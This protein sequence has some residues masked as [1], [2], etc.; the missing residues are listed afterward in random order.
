[1]LKKNDFLEIDFIARVKGTE[2][3]FDTTLLEEAKKANMLTEEDEKKEKEVE[4]SQKRFKP[5]KLCIGQGMVIAGLDKALEGKETG[6][7]Y[8]VE[9]QPQD[10]FGLR[11]PKLVK[12]FSLS[13][14]H[15]RGI[16]PVAGMVLT[17]DNMLARISTVSSG[18]V[19]VD[20]NSPLASK[21][22]VY[23]FRINRKI[24]NKE[25]KIE[26]LTNFFLGKADKIILEDKKAILEF[27]SKLPE[28]RKEKFSKKAKEILGIELEI[29]EIKETEAK[30]EGMSL[31]NKI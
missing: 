8:E 4:E 18:R 6:K 15:E 19:I 5:L 2:Q 13:A 26:I 12:L 21:A 30:Q 31:E 11:N 3:V 16:N 27:K 29:K 23:R 7:W 10:A 22:V 20:F 14:F 17:L 24:Q 28:K 25:E 1:M 9:I